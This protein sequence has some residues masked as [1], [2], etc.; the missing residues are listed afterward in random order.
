MSDNSKAKRLL[1]K[2][3]DV[4]AKFPDVGVV[5]ACDDGEDAGATTNLELDVALDLLRD[6]AEKIK[7][8]AI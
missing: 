6:A 4:C 8:G 7:D 1:R 3:E 2:L 5:I